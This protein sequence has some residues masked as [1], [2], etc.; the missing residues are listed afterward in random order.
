MIAVG[1]DALPMWAWWVVGVVAFLIL[2]AGTLVG[3]SMIASLVARLWYWLRIAVWG[4]RHLLAHR[5]VHP[6]CGWC[7]IHVW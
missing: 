7:H 2:V 5:Q 1:G 4:F 3:I 6:E